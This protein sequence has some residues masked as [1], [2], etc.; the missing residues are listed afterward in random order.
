MFENCS[1]FQKYPIFSSLDPLFLFTFLKW[2]CLGPH[3]SG[4]NK[5]N[6][7]KEASSGKGGVRPKMKASYIGIQLYS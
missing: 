7:I 6:V 4:C 3:L 5:C 2:T 1:L